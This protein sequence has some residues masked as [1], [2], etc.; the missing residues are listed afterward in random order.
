MIFAFPIGLC[1][2][3]YINEYARAGWLKICIIFMTSHLAGIPSIV[4]GIFG[5]ALFVN[6]LGFGDSILS[7]SLTLALMALPIVIR[8]TQES[9]KSV[10]NIHRESSAA[11]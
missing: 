10:D 7:A 8:I 6:G 3:L 2:G 1:A 9:L 11:L 4:F 5:V